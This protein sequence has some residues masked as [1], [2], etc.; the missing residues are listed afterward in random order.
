[1]NSCNPITVHPIWH[2]PS[3]VDT[4][5][6]YANVADTTDS[7]VAHFDGAAAYT[8]DAAANPHTKIRLI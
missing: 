2:K 3:R 6:A 8:D 7:A 1:M 5:A 4:V